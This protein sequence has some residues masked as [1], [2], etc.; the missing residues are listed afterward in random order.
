MTESGLLM[1]ARAR[2]QR[3]QRQ[4]KEGPHDAASQS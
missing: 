2:K 1:A 3:R 4:G